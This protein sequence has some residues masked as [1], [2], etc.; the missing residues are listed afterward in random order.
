ML[1]IGP[2]HWIRPFWLSI[3]H[4]DSLLVLILGWCVCV[5]LNLS[6]RVR[7]SLFRAWCPIVH[8]W[9]EICFGKGTPCSTFSAL[10]SVC[11][12]I[13]SNSFACFLSAKISPSTHHLLHLQ[14]KRTTSFWTLGNLVRPS[15]VPKFCIIAPPS[16]RRQ[17]IKFHLQSIG[18]CNQISHVSPKVTWLKSTESQ[19]ESGFRNR[20]IR[21]W[22]RLNYSTQ[23]DQLE[24]E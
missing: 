12:L 6:G 22:Y 20:Q 4:M 17:D 16:P 3:S 13:W 15:N 19:W 23:Y 18:G 10:G 24:L 5:S 9:R 8:S 11:S 7:G 1:F 21:Y 2:G 14:K